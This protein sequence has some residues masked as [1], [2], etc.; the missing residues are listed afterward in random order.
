[1]FQH[2]YFALGLIPIGMTIAAS[3]LFIGEYWYCTHECK[4]EHAC[5]FSTSFFYLSVSLYTTYSYVDCYFSIILD[6]HLM[7]GYPY[8]N[9]STCDPRSTNLKKN[10]FTVMLCCRWNLLFNIRGLSRNLRRS[11][12]VYKVLLLCCISYHYDNLKIPF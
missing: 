6:G 1:M 5:R 2:F 4:W 11:F 3:N 10:T 8:F 9:I 12:H 7:S